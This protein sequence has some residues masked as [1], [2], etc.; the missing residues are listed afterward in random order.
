MFKP[1]AV[2]VRARSPL[3]LEKRLVLH[4]K[5]V[6]AE[7]RWGGLPVSRRKGQY[8]Q[9][10][11]LV[12]KGLGGGVPAKLL[13]MIDT[14]NK[15]GEK[16]TRRVCVPPQPRCSTPTPPGLEG[17]R[18]NDLLRRTECDLR[19]VSL[20]LPGEILARVEAR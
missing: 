19:P 11:L 18:G 15:S 9:E 13:I 1:A 7:L 10:C 4:A 17:S 6:R 3:P 20:G 2:E 16:R 12:L 14:S 8:R 5:P